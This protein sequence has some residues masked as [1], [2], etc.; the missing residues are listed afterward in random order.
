[1][2]FAII[3]TNFLDHVRLQFEALSQFWRRACNFVI[4]SSSLALITTQA[5]VAWDM[6]NQR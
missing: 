6:V 4:T 2:P 5:L 3:I 1:L